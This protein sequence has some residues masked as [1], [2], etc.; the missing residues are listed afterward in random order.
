M[1][2]EYWSLLLLKTYLI[3]GAGVYY[4]YGMYLRGGAGHFIVTIRTLRSQRSHEHS[5]CDISIFHPRWK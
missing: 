1:T 4:I 5:I 3:V 2:F